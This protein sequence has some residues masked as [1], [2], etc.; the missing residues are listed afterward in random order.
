MGSSQKFQVET[1]LCLSY[2]LQEQI[3]HNIR[4]GLIVFTV[5]AEVWQ[6]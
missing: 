1:F 5:A 3:D 2:F 6:L 4:H